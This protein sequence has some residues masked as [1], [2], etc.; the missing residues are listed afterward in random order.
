[1]YPA[2]I[3][4]NRR[5][6]DRRTLKRIA[7]VCMVI[8][9]VTLAFLERVILPSTGELAA[10]SS[11]RLFC[12]DRIGR[13]IGRQTFPIMIFFLA[14]GFRHTGNRWKYGGRLLVTAVVSELP[15]HLLLYTGSVGSRQ[16]VSRN[17]VWTLLL[18]YLAVWLTDAVFGRWCL[19]D[20]GE[21]KASPGRTEGRQ[22]AG[23]AAALLICAGLYCCAEWLNTDYGGIGVAAAVLCYLLRGIPGAGP[24]AMLVL[25]GSC[26]EYEWF[27]L[28][29]CVLL[30]LY[31]GEMYPNGR[32]EGR[33]E[34]LTQ[35]GEAQHG[36]RENRIR[37]WLSRYS[38]YLF[39]PLHLFLLWG[40]RVLLAGD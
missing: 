3:K 27:A 6:I 15:F 18:G 11:E 16:T 2:E 31:R 39:Y 12:L 8:D 10:L 25:L 24:L 40:L 4:R 1:M 38:F 17:T 36:R 20:P 34:Q 26:N 35:Q 19:R 5:S 14:E 23:A 28:P 21:E 13:A 22:L 32:Q 37:Q 33:Q 9:H 7:L 30:C 29:G